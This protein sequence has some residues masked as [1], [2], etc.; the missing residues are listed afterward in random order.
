[1]DETKDVYLTN[2]WLQIATGD[3]SEA[4]IVQVVTGTVY[5]RK[6]ASKPDSDVTGLRLFGVWGADSARPIWIRAE[7]EALVVV[8]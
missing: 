5:M 1:M 8:S 4:V 7:N 3:E 2:E 6:S